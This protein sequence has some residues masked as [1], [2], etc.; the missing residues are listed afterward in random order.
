MS[1]VKDSKS[2]ALHTPL[3]GNAGL[4]TSASEVVVWSSENLGLAANIHKA[5][6]YPPT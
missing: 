5:V 3:S 4:G 1:L 6:A 2:H